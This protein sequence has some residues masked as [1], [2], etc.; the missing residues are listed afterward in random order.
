ME[1]FMLNTL[2]LATFCQSKNIDEVISNIK[3][4]FDI[5]GDKIFILQDK[6]SKHKKILTYNIKKSG[7]TIFSD[8]ISNTI[9]LHR[10]KETNTLYT[11]NALNEIVKEQ[12]NGEVSKDFTVNWEDY[13][14]TLLIT[15]Y[16]DL[17]SKTVLKSINTSLI[18]IIN[19]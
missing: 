7:N 10:K 14:N 4:N 18:K 13:R 9:S 8:V 6:S 16:D 2:L 15:Y 11:L 19:I 1:V 17:S 12:N 5:M 3:D